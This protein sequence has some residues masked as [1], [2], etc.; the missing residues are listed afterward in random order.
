VV[1]FLAALSFGLFIIWHKQA[2]MAQTEKKAEKT[3]EPAD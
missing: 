3:E 1:A 2:K